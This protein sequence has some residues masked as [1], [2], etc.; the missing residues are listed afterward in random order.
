MT[1]RKATALALALVL[2][3]LIGWAFSADAK[4]PKRASLRREV[5]LLKARIA[6]LEGRL[7]FE[8]RQPSGRGGSRDT[9]GFFP[10]TGLC[11]DPCAVDSDEDGTGDCEDPCPCDPSNTD[12]DG[13]GAADCWDP[14]PDDATDAGID[15][16]RM[17]SDGDGT[18][19]CEDPCAW[20]PAAPADEDGDGIG[21]CT[22]PCPWGEKGPCVLPPGGAPPGVPRPEAR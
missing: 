13:D 7:S 8:E 22:D 3:T 1:L 12:T 11:G 5:T 19:D 10:G 6:E 2:G 21:D 4:K 16:C 9:P 18:T 20:D 17:D 15:P 14:C